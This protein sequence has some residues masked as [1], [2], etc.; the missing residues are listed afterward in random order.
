MGDQVSHHELIHGI[1]T[2]VVT[3]KAKVDSVELDTFWLAPELGCQALQF[4]RFTDQGTVLSE[5]LLLR[6]D[7]T[8]PDP[9]L[10]DTGKSYESVGPS[11]LRARQYQAGGDQ[12]EASDF[13]RWAPDLER[14]FWTL[15]IGTG[16]TTLFL[17]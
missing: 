16:G 10:F 2:V 6:L 15:V 8:E 11:E 12:V 13:Q 5:N 3:A 1:D 14:E 7:L 9:S 17:R 4:R